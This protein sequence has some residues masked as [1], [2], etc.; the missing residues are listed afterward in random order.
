[1]G[2]CQWTGVQLLLFINDRQEESRGCVCVCVTNARM[3]F[4]SSGPWQIGEGRGR[5]HTHTHGDTKMEDKV[6]LRGSFC[7]KLM[8]LVCVVVTHRRHFHPDN[9][10]DRL[11]LKTFLFF[12]LKQVSVSVTWSHYSFHGV[13][14]WINV[15]CLLCTWEICTLL[16]F[17]HQVSHVQR[18]LCFR[19]ATEFDWHDPWRHVY[20]G[21]RLKFTTQRSRG[22][23]G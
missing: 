7:W 18:R 23:L 15:T 8:C 12:F 14:G 22:V 9:L 19:R 4:A 13:S 2:C 5:T 6:P 1:M 20:Q 16:F 11:N 3:L 17:K 21:P 10:F